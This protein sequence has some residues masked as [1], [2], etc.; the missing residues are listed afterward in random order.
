MALQNNNMNQSSDSTSEI[1]SSMK[2]IDAKEQ[3]TSF[4]TALKPGEELDVMFN[5]YRRAAK[6]NRP[7]NLMSMT[8][9]T[10]VIKYCSHLQS[11]HDI[12]KT[13]TLDVSYGISENQQYRITLK[14][15]DKINNIMKMMFKRTNHIIFVMLV[16]K[17]PFDDK[18]E[19]MK[20]IR[21]TSIYDWDERDI[22]F[23]VSSELK[24]PAKEK[25]NL[26]D[27][28]GMEMDKISFRY[29]ERLSVTLIDNASMKMVLDCTRVKSSNKITTLENSQVEYEVELDIQKK[30]V[31]ESKKYHTEIMKYIDDIKKTLQQNSTIIDNHVIDDVKAQYMQ[32]MYGQA[33]KHAIYAM[34]PVSMET[35]HL[36]KQLPHHYSVTEK[37]DGEYQVLIIQNERV[38]LMSTNMVVRDTSVTVNKKYNGTILEGEYIY[39]RDKKKFVYLAF[40][41]LWYCGKDIRG[42]ASLYER[43]ELTND[44]MRTC[45]HSKRVLKQYTGEFILGPIMKHHT[46]EMQAY[47]DNL[48]DQINKSTA[49]AFV[50]KYFIFPVGAFENEIYMYSKLMWDSYTHTNVPYE[51]DGLTFTPLDQKY[52]NKRADMKRPIFKWKPANMSSIDFWIEFDKDNE[53][54]IITYF[55]KTD[56]ITNGQPYRICMLH[57]GTGTP[58]RPVP[59]MPE[60]QLNKVYLPVINDDVR[61]QAGIIINDKTVVE[62][63]FNHQMPHRHH[64]W[65]P[66]RTRHDKTESVRK[67]KKKYG[68]NQYI[69]SLIWRSIQQNITMEDIVELSSNNYKMVVKKMEEGLDKNIMAIDRNQDAYYQN[70]DQ[71]NKQGR[72]WHNYIKSQLIVTYC[73]DR[74]VNGKHYRMKVF[75]MGVGKGGDNSKYYQARVRYM[76][77]ID[78]DVHGLRLALDSAATRYKQLKSNNTG[79]PD[80]YYAVGDCSL[81]LDMETQSANMDLS[82]EDKAVLTKYFGKTPTSKGTK[83]DVFSSQFAIHYLFKNDTSLHNLCNNINK[84]LDTNGFF[85]ITTFD[86]KRVRTLLTSKD[87]H[88]EEFTTD[89][90]EKK[91]LYEIV[92]KY[93]GNESD[94]KKTGIAVDVMNSWISDSYMTEYLVDKD[95]II[96]TFANKCGLKCIETELFENYYHTTKQFFAT[97]VDTEDNPK[98]KKYIDNV[99]AFLESDSV[100]NTKFKAYSNLSRFYVFQKQSKN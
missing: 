96:E 99:K 64:A 63:Y 45:F 27:I 19:I 9:F 16:Q 38:Y 88:T 89:D 4:L 32:C 15:V 100:L 57:V 47:F 1:E 59:F 93:D 67:F 48:R 76:V 54:K 73:S 5:N 29:K 60:E 75:D 85:I 87:R 62:F 97:V 71:L 95:H 46:T 98:N 61:D 66:M 24:V 13:T 25:S 36:I 20:K 11:T 6:N 44:V 50:D 40:D 3:L 77:G 10:Y 94:F 82:K 39:I 35:Q 79:V 72:Q 55:D 68:N 18:I 69:A 83:F 58:E 2:S 34:Q 74:K 14:G 22:R 17:E 33:Q 28:N 53:G 70:K 30:K 21:S 91:I 23:R 78:Y 26:K 49:I 41:T 37:A 80:M 65:V 92:R 90:G 31:S 42:I 81:S 12:K 8:E 52:T 7:P 84:Y 56:T 51:L 86:S 43:L